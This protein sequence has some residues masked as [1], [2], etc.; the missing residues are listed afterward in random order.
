MNR[1]TK[2]LCALTVFALLITAGSARGQAGPDANKPYDPTADAL[3]AIAKADVGQYDW[4]TWFGWPKRN[5]TPHGVNI[6]T[7]WDVETGHNIKWKAALGSQTYGNP[8]VANGKVYVGTNNGAGWVKRFPPDVD[9]GCLVCFD[10]KTGKFLWQHSS[11]KLPQ[12]RVVDWPLQGICCAPYI[13]GDRLWYVT[14]R[15][16]VVCLDTEGFHDGENDGPFTAEPWTTTDDADVIWKLDMMSELGTHQHNMCSCSVLCVGDILLVNTSNGVDASHINIPAP[17][18]PSFLG[19]DRNTG[20]VLWTD[21]SPG[22][23]ILHGQWSSPTFAVL[24]GQPQALFTGG[25]GWIYSFDPAGD[26]QGNSKL[27]WKF[28]CNPKGTRYIL[29]GRGTRN[30]LIATPVVYDDLVYIAVG[31]DPEHG[32]GEG[33]LWC[34]D[35]A[36]K[37]DGSDVSPT[38]AVDAEGKVLPVRR[39]QAID[40]EAGEREIPN[41]DSALVWHYGADSREEYKKLPFEKAMHRTIGSVAIKNDILYIADFSGLF[42]CLDAKETTD[43][44]KPVVYWTYDMFAAAWGSPLIVENKVYIGDE[45]GDVAIFE[46]SREMKLIGEINMRNA[47]YSTPIVANNV[48]Y[49]SNKDTLFAITAEDK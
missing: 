4:P 22:T 20:K 31:Q 6:P 41:P 12:G 26:G 44:G 37:L 3:A 32:D 49:I 48:L 16:E 21:K 1:G 2:P 30:E 28:D 47:V 42:H 29:G 45:D 39:L 38:L 10:E 35:P 18:A 25:D 46:L 7:E 23:N 17:N 5:N 40:P 34:I 8:T 15:G 13:D 11:R 14:S 43:D 33:H 36:K 19:L 9:L 27:L 24:G